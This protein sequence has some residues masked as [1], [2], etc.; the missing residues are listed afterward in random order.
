MQ[1]LLELF[2]DVIVKIIKGQSLVSLFVIW[3]VFNIRHANVH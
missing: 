3:D 2:I 1:K